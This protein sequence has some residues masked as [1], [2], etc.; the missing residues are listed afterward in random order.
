[1]CHLSIG[2]F[3]SSARIFLFPPLTRFFVY[4]YYYFLSY[5]QQK[6]NGAVVSAALEIALGPGFES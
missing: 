6:T 4:Y 5:V 3:K 2:P 1:M